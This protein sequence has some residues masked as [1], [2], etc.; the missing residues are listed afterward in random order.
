MSESFEHLT[1]RQFRQQLAD[2]LVSS[3]FLP[4]SMKL[5]ELLLAAGFDRPAGTAWSEWMAAVIY[6]G[7][8]VGVPE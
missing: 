8:T 7:L 4:Y 6:R 3:T 5:D 1:P 2:L